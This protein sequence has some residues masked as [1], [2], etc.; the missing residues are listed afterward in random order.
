MVVV[1]KKSGRVRICIDPTN[2]NE[3]I[4]RE[5]YP[6]NII[7]DIS[8]RLNGRKYYS[9][10]D[11]NMGCF[12]IKLSERSPTLTTFNTPFSRY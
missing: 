6:I 3:A 11:A 5:H 10:L 12:Q 9:V 8:T 2:L 7:E 4:L 1:T